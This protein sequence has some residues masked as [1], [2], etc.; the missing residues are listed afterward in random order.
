MRACR[1]HT[2]RLPSCTSACRIF[3]ETPAP[4]PSSAAGKRELL[5][6]RLLLLADPTSSRTHTH[7]V[8]SP[9]PPTPTRSST[10]QPR[11]ILT[12]ALT[13]APAAIQP[14]RPSPAHRP[15]DRSQRR[16]SIY[17]SR[18][19]NDH[20]LMY[21]GASLIFLLPRPGTPCPCLSGRIFPKCMLPR[22]TRKPSAACVLFSVSFCVYIVSPTRPLPAGP[23][24][25]SPPRRHHLQAPHV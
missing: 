9:A 23:C 18:A 21:V 4:V 11:D 15:S 3:V 22:P 19:R 14:L 20:A 8:T 17:L 13:P 1:E 2:C 5:L 25:H 24:P 10:H 6:R 12:P 16:S 7:T